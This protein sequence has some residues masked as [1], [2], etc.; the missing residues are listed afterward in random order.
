MV[1]SCGGALTVGVFVETAVAVEAVAALVVGSV[2]EVEAVGR[3][4]G[5]RLRALLMDSVRGMDG[6]TGV[7]AV[8]ATL[9]GWIG[10]FGLIGCGICDGTATTGVVG[11]LGADVKATSDSESPASSVPGL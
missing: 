5:V 10:V 6:F 9:T 2:L 3:V 1:D 8:I 11:R 4:T 7:G